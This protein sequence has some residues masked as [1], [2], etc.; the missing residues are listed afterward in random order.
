MSKI[1]WKDV[2][3]RFEEFQ[4]GRITLREGFSPDHPL[5][6]NLN[7]FLGRIDY[8]TN[9]GDTVAFE[10]SQALKSVAISNHLFYTIIPKEDLLKELVKLLLHWESNVL[11]K[12]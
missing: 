4:E 1:Q 12:S 11:L 7:V 6:M 8:I 10:N 9:K 5:Q 3:Y 2:I